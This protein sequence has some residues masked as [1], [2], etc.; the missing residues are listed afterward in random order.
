MEVEMLSQDKKQN[1]VTFLVKGATPA[2]AN[3][4]RKSII[5][6]VPTMAIE[7]VEIRKNSSVLY[8]EMIAHRL[9]LVPLVTDLSAYNLP[10][11]CTCKGEGCSKCQLQLS[12]K[13]KGPG[14]VYASEMKSKDPKV[15]PVYP[16]M[17]IV[18]LIKG[19]TLELEATAVLGKGK[20]HSKW[21]PALAFYKYKPVIDIKK[22]VKD[23]KAVADSCPVDVYSV[24]NK[25]LVINDDAMNKCHLCGACAD[26]DPEHIKLNESDKDFI[27]TV[28]SWGQ[29][30]P[31]EIVSTA[32]ELMKKKCDDVISLIGK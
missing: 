10:E 29:L 25:E 27:F 13:A 7:D 19:Q 11:D 6:D 24:K 14:F 20:E 5:D 31:A 28:E 17:P 9:G 4:L 26:V 23:P 3:M 21:T 30:A 15:V 1:R 12:L 22:G 2:F 18:K 8:D 32:V 16:K